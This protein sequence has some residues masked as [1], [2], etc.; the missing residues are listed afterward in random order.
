[1]LRV[2]DDMEVTVYY[3]P[4]QGFFPTLEGGLDMLIDMNTEVA[5]CETL[6]QLY[7]CLDGVRYSKNDYIDDIIRTNHR[8]MKYSEY[9]AMFKDKLNQKYP[10]APVLS[11]IEI[12]A[13]GNIKAPTPEYLKP[14]DG[15]QKLR[16]AGL[17]F[18]IQR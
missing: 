16:D 17:N 7:V 10:D 11:T 12:D 18:K 3:I 1:M 6:Q 14:Q 15:F 2:K 13:N 5:Y 8:T 4:K 9:V